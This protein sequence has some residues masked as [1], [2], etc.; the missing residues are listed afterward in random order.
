MGFNAWLCVGVMS[1][2]LAIAIYL[3]FGYT[4][5][6]LSKSGSQAIVHFPAIQDLNELQIQNQSLN[7]ENRSL[8][9]A[10]QHGNQE[11]RSLAFKQ[12]QN[13]LSQ[14]NQLVFVDNIE[15][16]FKSE[17][18]LQD[19]LHRNIDKLN[20]NGRKLRLYPNG[21][22]F[23]IRGEARMRIDLLCIDDL[24][25]FC[26]IETKVDKIEAQAI[27]QI[28]SYMGW[29]DTHLNKHK[30]KVYGLLIGLN[31]D[32]KLEYAAMKKNND[33]FIFEYRLGF[34]RI[35]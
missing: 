23:A 13:E 33:I 34:K 9:A 14:R 6:E 11:I 20:F 15:K 19:Y 31:H 8:T 7:I 22:E 2:T 16:I 10:L 24:D 28:S 18:D 25:N 30:K 4:N 17:R 5:V 29:V 27:A 26:V 3:L 35:D 1:L 21:Y 12:Q 32:I